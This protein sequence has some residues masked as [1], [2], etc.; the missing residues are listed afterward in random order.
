MENVRNHADVRV[1]PDVILIG[2]EE[3]GVSPAAPDGSPA[4]GAG[5]A[6]R[7]RELRRFVEPGLLVVCAGAVLLAVQVTT[8][9]HGASVTRPAIAS[10][11]T[12]SAAPPTAEGPPRLLAPQTASPGER[13]TV[14]AYRNPRLCGSAQLRFDGAPVKHRLASYVG[15]QHPD[16]ME[17]FLTMQVP[18]SVTPG[19]HTIELYGPMPGGSTGPICADV[20]EHQARLATT[21]ITVGPR[22]V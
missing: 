21:T 13:I 8:R 22:R 2:P 15:P 6:V 1:E 12:P 10:S 17:M 4:R 3:S 11:A 16:R 14:L 20:R 19:S 9:G 18:G 5:S 7:L